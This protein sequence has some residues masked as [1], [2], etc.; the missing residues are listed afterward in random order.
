MN[1][2]LCYLIIEAIEIGLAYSK[3]A[4]SLLNKEPIRRRDS[5]S[6]RQR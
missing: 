5:W 4:A 3:A 6:M 1:V 2:H